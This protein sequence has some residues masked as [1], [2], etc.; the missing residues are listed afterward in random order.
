MDSSRWAFPSCSCR[1]L[2]FS[3]ACFLAVM[4]L[5][6]PRTPVTFPEESRSGAS[7]VP[8]QSGEPGNPVTFSR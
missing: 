6:T 7:Q 5:E 3:S 8:S 1:S 2:S 4:F